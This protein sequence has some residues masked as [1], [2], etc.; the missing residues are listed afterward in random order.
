MI[1]RRE[2]NSGGQDK[3]KGE[4]RERIKRPG[5][6]EKKEGARGRGEGS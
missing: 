6:K 4:E 2:R 5:K 1:K 3:E